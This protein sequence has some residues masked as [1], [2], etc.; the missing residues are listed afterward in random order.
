VLR[1]C[2]IEVVISTVSNPGLEAEFAMV[3]AAKQ[4]GVQLF[5]PSEFGIPTTGW[6]Q[7]QGFAGLKARVAAYSKSQELPYALF[8]VSQLETAY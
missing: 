1:E 6:E 3:D 5:L 7:D 4:A 2:K 8:F